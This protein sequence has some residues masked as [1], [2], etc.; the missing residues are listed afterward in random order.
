MLAVDIEATAC[1][2]ADLASAREAR[3]FVR[4]MVRP[5][6]ADDAVDVAELLTSE[7]VTNALLHARDGPRLFVGVRAGAVRVTVEDSDPAWPRRRHVPPESVSG[8][9]IALVDELASEWGVERMPE[10]GK[11]V[12]FEI[13]G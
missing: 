13:R 12:W 3:D 11:R 5:R 9:G 2:P 1:L 4:S 8:R 7:V 10:N 6:L